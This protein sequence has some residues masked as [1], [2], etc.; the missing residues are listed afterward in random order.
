MLS[1]Y[2]FICWSPV[3]DAAAHPLYKW[4][5]AESTRDTVYRPPARPRRPSRKSRSLE[6]HSSSTSEP[7]TCVAEGA[8]GEGED[9][10]GRYGKYEGLTVTFVLK[11]TIAHLVMPSP[12][13]L[14]GPCPG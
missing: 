2:C 12:I 5:A 1:R 13:P 8:L 4:A 14:G 11:G 7:M 10:G 3:N 9:P 6:R